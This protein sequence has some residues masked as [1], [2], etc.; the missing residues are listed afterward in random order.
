MQTSTDRIL[1]THA[2]SLPRPPRL[3]D[4]VVRHAQGEAVDQAAYAAEV[5]A[6]V[7]GVVRRQ[8]EV[9]LD[10]V[11]DGEMSKPGFFQYVAERFT[12]FEGGES[13]PVPRAD[14]ADFPEYAKRV[15]A[16]G[17]GVILNPSCV[18]PVAL[19]DRAAVERDLANLTAATR[20]TPP[21]EAFVPAA[22]PGIIAQ[23]LRNSFYPS[24]EQYVWALSDA[25][26]DEYRLI[27]EHGF[28]LQVD[29]PDLAMGRHVMFADAP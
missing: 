23:N 7:G 27:V 22:S 14:L 20:Q 21:L 3:L 6:A 2:G 4:L 26:R 16:V 24:Y 19:K 29:C 18:G 13:T 12:G 11:S 15:G 8:V 25:L 5:A 28:V 17:A 1:T 9:G 10:V